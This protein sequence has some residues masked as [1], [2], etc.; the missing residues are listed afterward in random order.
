MTLRTSAQINAEIHGLAP[1]LFERVRDAV[2]R[3][4]TR[5]DSQDALDAHAAN[6]AL[7]DRAVTATLAHALPRELDHRALWQVLWQRVVYAGTRASKATTEIGS[8]GELVP[9]FQDLDHYDPSLYTYDK[10]EWDAFSRQWKA[11][12]TTTTRQ[13]NWLVHAKDEPD[14]NPAAHFARAKTS[15]AV[16]KILTKDDASYPGLKFSAKSDK[17]EKYL[18]VAHFLHGH[19]RSGT[20]ALD[21]YTD[22]HAFSAQHLTGEA[23]LRERAALDKVRRRFQAQ[24]GE[25]TALHTMMDLGLKTIKP[26]R[27]MTYLFSQ[28]GWLQT[29]PA[30]LDKALV[31][32]SYLRAEVV[33]EMTARADVMAASLDHA[34]FERAHRLL[35]IW[36]V[37]YGQ[38]PEPAY[39]IT[40]NLQEQGQGIRALLD[41]VR[42]E[43]GAAISEAEAAARWPLREFAAVPAARR[44]QS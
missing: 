26:D 40:V 28:L 3:L 19:R 35:D 5:A 23:W 36:L 8:M 25:L 32:R 12:Q 31:M 41:A 20:S 37:K 1:A 24:V 38:E 16:W 43:A 15:P 6:Q 13:T 44:K 39:G 22:G 17:M 42:S 29:L 21:H 14:W 7:L 34:G 33:E 4:A 27:V 10:K 11:R 2:T 9:L 18:K 30:S